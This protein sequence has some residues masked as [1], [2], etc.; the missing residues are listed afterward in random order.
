MYPYDGVVRAQQLALTCH[1]SGDPLSMIDVTVDLDDERNFAS[2]KI[3][4]VIT[5]KLLAT[6]ADT[7][8]LA[9]NHRK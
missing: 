3:D 5:D 6:K 1:V 9:A 7:Q 2:T 4:D 8:A